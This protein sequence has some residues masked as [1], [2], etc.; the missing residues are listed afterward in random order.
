MLLQYPVKFYLFSDYGRLNP[1]VPLE[2][3]GDC[4]ANTLFL[5]GL[6][7][8]DDALVLSEKQTQCW[9][10]KKGKESTPRYVFKKYIFT[11]KSKRYNVIECTKEDLMREVQELLPNHGTFLFMK[12]AVTKL[13]HSTCIY[14]N[15]NGAIE[16]ADLQTEEIIRND[17]EDRVDIYLSKY[18]LFYIPET[19]TGPVKDDG[20]SGSRGSPAK[21]MPSPA[22]DTYSPV[23]ASEHLI[24]S[25]VKAEP[26]IE[27]PVRAE[28]LIESP[29]RL[30]RSRRD[31]L[32]ENINAFNYVGVRSP[33][34][35]T[36]QPS[37][38]KRGGT[39]KRTRRKN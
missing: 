35:L 18:D 11:D 38:K 29:S 31:P 15:E 24:E 28:S 36:P 25:P 10:T 8:L 32:H 13:G 5:L 33:L 6:I 30:I 21:K 39:R 22:R 2:E 3:A 9:L 17:Y 16:L 14:K 4:G 1:E 37:K 20:L 34:P 26:L 27:N 12:D 7:E 19:T 23:R